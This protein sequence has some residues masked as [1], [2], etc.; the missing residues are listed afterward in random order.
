MTLSG[1]TPCIYFDQLQFLKVVIESGPTASNIERAT[2][3]EAV[4]I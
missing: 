3:P 2:E 4:E 1:V